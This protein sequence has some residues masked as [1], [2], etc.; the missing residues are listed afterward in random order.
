MS[1]ARIITF[2]SYKGGTGRSMALAN[3]A[4]ILASTG[5]NVLLI[6]W[7]LE[8]PGLH[9][10][11]HPFLTDKELTSTEGLIDFV[12]QYADRAARKTRRATNN[13]YEPY[14]NIL[15]YASSLNH[16]FQKGTIDF[17]PAGRQGADYATR[18]N[19]FNWQHFYEQL[20]G[21]LFFEA[22]K[23]SM[24]GYD[25]VLIDSRTGVSDTSGICTVQMPDVLV[26]CFTLNIQSIEG[27]AAVAESAL[28]QR[29]DDRGRATLK[30]FPVPTRVELTEQGKLKAARD[31]ARERFSPLLDHL[32]K[33]RDQY[34]EGV[35][36][37]YQPYYAYEEIL[38]VFGDAPGKPSSMLSSMEMLAGR[39]T[40]RR[41]PLRMRASTQAERDAILARYARGSIE[42]FPN[43]IRRLQG[44]TASVRAVSL[45]P[46][47]KQAL[48][49]SEDKTVRLWD[50]ATGETV[51]TFEGHFDA[52]QSVAFTPDG[53]T[54]VSGGSDNQVLVWDLRRGKKP[55]QALEHSAQVHA[56]ALSADG[57][58]VVSGTAD[59]DVLQ[60]EIETGL[61]LWSFRGHAGA[62]AAVSISEDGR[63]AVSGGHD[64]I[65]ILRDLTSGNPVRT[66][67]GHSGE[68][69]SLCLSGDGRRLVSGSSDKRLILW[70]VQTGAMLL[71]M[72]GHNGKVYATD[73]SRDGRYALSGSADKT[74][75]L[76]NLESGKPVRTFQGH[77]SP[78]NSVRFAA[79]SRSA[80][81]AS[82]DGS[83]IV[84]DL[85]SA[86][87]T[88]QEEVRAP[89]VAPKLTK[90]KVVATTPHPATKP[91]VV[92]GET[93]APWFYVSVAS[94]D[95]D[96]YFERFLADLSQEI[97]VLRGRR[98][99]MFFDNIDFYVGEIASDLW[100]RKLRQALR[101]C[102]VAVC[103]IAPAYFAS[104]V[105][106]KE[107]AV[108]RE[109]NADSTRGIFPINWA[110]PFAL[111]TVMSNFQ[112]FH[113]NQPSSY[114]ELGLAHL[115]RLSRYRDEYQTMVSDLAIQLLD[116]ATKNP[117]PEFPGTTD[118]EHIRSAFADEERRYPA[119]DGIFKEFGVKSHVRESTF[120]S[121]GF[122]SDL[123]QVRFF[124]VEENPFGTS[125]TFIA[126]EIATNLKLNYFG[127]ES[128][129][130]EAVISEIEAS[131][132]T[133]SILV[134]TVGPGLEPFLDPLIQQI[135]MVDP[136]RC[137]LLVLS[138]VQRALPPLPANLGYI[139]T[140]LVSEVSYRGALET[141][142]VNIRHSNIAK[143]LGVSV[144]TE[145]G[146]PSSPMLPTPA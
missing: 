4:W 87:A 90:E 113:K 81:S 18:V 139:A 54:G 131:A 26:V 14:A 126:M 61:M 86:I 25:Y 55:K 71:K 140:G 95:R 51:R 99:N 19:S 133:S 89:E 118:Y 59:G 143:G 109:R 42:S 128:S 66:F 123:N 35:E 96:K 102:K 24:A 2:Y 69:N 97:S 15:Q 112:L 121:G 77:S 85:S 43:L 124:F 145:G 37:L 47:N 88:T 129:S 132:E 56:V 58:Y 29:R 48:S 44:H 108:F 142:I 134:I 45:S 20:D 22:A 32:G 103:I 27:A 115:M 138:G 62:V 53:T 67:S 1:P 65:I 141:A 73:M 17:V 137:A 106:G 33:D 16:P 91:Q 5:K 93:D 23:E 74:L 6:D 68:V 119:F 144:R 12:V 7:D 52:V 41:V 57:E 136:T 130:P 110:R 146:G 84:W 63:F 122:D 125:L 70:D 120:R 107:F 3:V 10:Y 30:I 104:T 80:L 28:A 100:L 111:P 135:E 13:W 49:G 72:R 94:T 8:A 105:C 75:M 127:S 76:W 82:D 98:V 114:M 78:V 116:M 11:L 38:S 31:V 117:L 83:L 34:W 60:W 79:D 36:V 9:R 21:G 64:N 40:G 92:D 39:L 101:T 46:D 50:V